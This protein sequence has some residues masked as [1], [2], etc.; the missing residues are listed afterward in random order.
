MNQSVSFF[1]PTRKGSQRVKNKNTR[2]FSNISGGLLELKLMQLVQSKRISEIILSTNDEDSIRVASLVNK[3]FGNKVL[4]VERPDEL[5]SDSTNLTDLINYVPNIITN[6]HILWGHVTTPFVTADDYDSAI[7][8]YFSCIKAGFDSLLSGKRFQ[9]Y[10]IKPDTNRAYNTDQESNSLR[11]PRTQDLQLL[12]EI[13]HAI[14]IASR[15]IY[16]SKKDRIGDMIYI[17]EMDA[18]KSFDIDWEDD[19]LIAEAIYDRYYK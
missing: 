7:E 16:I 14:F 10:L 17:H 9:N 11:W 6:E 2:T 5:C 19:F 12:Y 4:I 1:L 15:N 3:R 8:I 13:N 18:I